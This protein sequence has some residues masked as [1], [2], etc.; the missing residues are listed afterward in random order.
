MGT[1]ANSRAPGLQYGDQEVGPAGNTCEQPGTTWSQFKNWMEIGWME[2]SEDIRDREAPRSL[3]LAP[4]RSRLQDPLVLR[5]VYFMPP[6]APDLVPTLP[7]GKFGSLTRSRST[8]GRQSPCLRCSCSLA[9]CTVR[10]TRGPAE[11]S[12]TAG[13]TC[14]DPGLHGFLGLS[15]SRKISSH[16]R[17]TSIGVEISRIMGTILITCPSSLVSLRTTQCNPQPLASKHNPKGRCSSQSGRP[18]L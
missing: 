3:L 13:D 12:D 18:P 7:E 2:F 1:R 14:G 16:A 6:Q 10:T 9:M 4:T 8:A 17:V 15:T 5:R 11:G